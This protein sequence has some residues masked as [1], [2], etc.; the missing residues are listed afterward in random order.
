MRPSLG[1]RVMIVCFVIMAASPAVTCA[2]P[3]RYR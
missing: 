2:E 3:P 1:T